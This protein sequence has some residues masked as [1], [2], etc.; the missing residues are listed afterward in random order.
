MYF[1]LRLW[2][3]TSGV[4]LRI[5]LA[6]LIGLISLPLSVARLALS[7]VVIAGIIQGRPFSELA[8]LLVAVALLILARGLDQVLKEE[9]ANR[10]AA[11]MKLRLRGL[12]YRH[13]LRLGPGPFDQRR[14]GDVLLSLVEGV[15]QLE[16]FFGQYLPQLIVAAVTPFLIFGLIAFLDLP[17]AL[18]FLVFALFSLIVPSLFH[19]WNAAAG[20]RRRLAYSALG[21]DF[22]D[23]I[24]G[25]ATLKAFGQSRAHG[26]RLAERARALYRGTMSVLAANTATG[27]LTLFGV[28]AGAALALVYGAVRV[29]QGEL[30]L[31]TLIIVLMLGVEVFRP[32]R[33]LTALYH[34]GMVAVSAT[35]H[36]YTLLDMRP[37]VEDGS[38]RLTLERP[39]NGSPAAQ[40]LTPSLRFEG[41]TFAYPGRDAALREV[42]FTLQPGETLGLVGPSGAGKSTIIWLLLRFFDPQSGRI[43]LGGQDLRELPLETVRRQFAIVAQDTYLFHGTVADNL[44]LGKPDASQTELEAAARAANAHD[45]IASLP[46]GYETL[47]GERGARLSGGQRQRIAIA[48]ALL[49]DAPILLLDEALSSVDSEN[50]AA[51]Q[52]ALDR[53]QR[54]RTTLVIAHRLSSV[55]GADRILVLDSGRLVETGSHAELIAR[56]GVYAH[57]MAEQQAEAVAMSDGRRLLDDDEPS[58]PEAEPT[59][60]LALRAAAG[61]DHDHGHSHGHEHNHDHNHSAPSAFTAAVDQ[62][63]VESLARSL[64]A[65]TVWRR[66]LDLVRP[67]WG[68]LGLTFFLGF[69]RAGSIVLLALVSAL[70]VGQVARG[71]PF[72]TTVVALAVLVPLMAVLTWLESWIAHDLAYRLLAEM[73]IAIYEVLDPLAPAYFQRRRSGDLASTVTGDVELIEYFFAHTIAPIAVAI[74]VPGLVLLGLAQIGL[75]LALVLAPFLLL[76]GFSPYLARRAAERIGAQTR[77]Q[78]GELNALI[79]DGIQGLRTLTAFQQGERFLAAI[80]AQG[81]VFTRYQLAFLRH[82]ALHNAVIEAGQ[83]FGS[84][85][86]LV[87][88]AWLVTQGRMAPTLLALATVTALA[89]FSPLLELAKTAKQLAETLAA[90]RRIFAIHD[91]PVPVRD[92]PGVV[93]RPG[94][95]RPLGLAFEQVGFAYGPRLPQ[96]LRG[97]ELDA[98]PGQLVAIVGRSGAGKTTAAHLVLRFWDPQQGR[99]VLDGHD[100]REYQLDALR[101]KI[102]LVA[103]DTYLFNTSLRDNLRIGRPDASQAEIEQAARRASIHDFIVGLPEGYDTQVGERGFHLSGGQRQR[104]AIARALLKDAPV[105]ILDEATSHLDAVSERQVHGALEDL[106]QGRTT[107]VIAHRLSTVRRADKI[108]VLDEGRLVEQGSHQEL[109]ERSGLYAQLVG[110]QV[111]SQIGARYASTNGAA[112]APAAASAPDEARA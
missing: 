66:L 37:E 107:L 21:A 78:L 38:G 73:R 49:R 35:N 112:H 70:L 103:Q 55:V 1:D 10:T 30:P 51:I 53:L 59:P 48:R 104:V 44:R 94:E 42:S 81:R 56:G 110:A 2:A 106:M 105:L 111:S 50:E 84:L 8:P 18:I 92:G 46:E 43:L 20:H 6:A 63:E 28:S 19:R 15:E 69:A 77:G 58:E 87:T 64:P 26:G 4:R 91:E 33:E 23:G 54:G 79:V 88:G 71:E 9:V 109:L 5:L 36:I 67:W 76:V 75:P 29:S 68:Q 16:T 34:R 108:L 45:F 57:L 47:V 102:A 32:L 3:M 41:V 72:N 80:E 62:V 101:K 90:A 74:I 97:L 95:H 25:L 39:A 86:V 99:I 24:Q 14:S 12:L 40:E 31:Q 61:H 60:S 85:A 11:E 93:E 96:A 98:R 65:P 83:A 13:V 52:E 89:A 22:L 82:Q 17:T 27:S 100:L 7:G